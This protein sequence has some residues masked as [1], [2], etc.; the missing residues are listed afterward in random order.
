MYHQQN[1]NIWKTWLLMT[2]FLILIIILGFLLAMYYGNPNILYT[3]FIF[4]L[5]LNFFSY[6]FS[7]TVALSMAGA[8]E[9]KNRNEHA[10]LWNVVENLSITAGLPK[11]KLYIID[12]PLPNAFATGRNENHSAVAVTSGLLLIL[13]KSELEGVI[14]HELSHIKN[15]DILLQTIIVVLAG[16]IAIVSDLFLRMTFF[17]G[18]DR[19]GGKNILIYILLL[20]A[21]ILAP[22]AATIIKLAI[23]RR[24]EFL[25]DSSGALLTRYPE[26]L[27]SALQKIS[28]YTQP[29]KNAHMATA[30]LYIVN[31]LGFSGNS[32][33]KEKSEK[34][35]SWLTKLFLTHPPTQD[36]IQ[37]LLKSQG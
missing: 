15:K 9:I 2:V 5:T 12:D 26:G 25:A 1:N 6:Y 14:A 32:D 13:N 18:G 16:V 23:S 7:D 37:A 29:L 10:E 30:H 34:E 19:E 11:P 22:L 8:T 4:S 35:I 31:P 20:V 3:A 36:R 21:I 17:G 24:R 28:S 33:H 27:A